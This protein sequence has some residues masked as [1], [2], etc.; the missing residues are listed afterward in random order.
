VTTINAAEIDS[1]PHDRREC[2]SLARGP[3]EA[4]AFLQAT[5]A[6]AALIVYVAHAGPVHGR[7]DGPTTT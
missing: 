1:T 5:Q 6:A 4:H 3:D 2:A 7:G